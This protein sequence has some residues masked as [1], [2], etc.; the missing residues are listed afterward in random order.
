MYLLQ[1]LYPDGP[2]T[3]D[4]TPCPAWARAW[5]DTTA[6]GLLPTD[7]ARGCRVLDPAGRVILDYAA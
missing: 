2:D 6:A 4:T 1:L 3:A 7:A 5:F